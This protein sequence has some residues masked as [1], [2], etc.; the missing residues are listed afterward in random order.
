MTLLYRLKDDGHDMWLEKA[1][2]VKKGQKKKGR[3]IPW[4]NI[5]LEKLVKAEISIVLYII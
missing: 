3:K 1:S 5:W 2:Q 4:S